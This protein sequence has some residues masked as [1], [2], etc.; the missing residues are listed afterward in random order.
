LNAAP[1][2]PK[3]ANPLEGLTEAQ[4]EAC[5]M[6]Y[7]EGK[8]LT[9]LRVIGDRLGIRRAAV[10]TRIKR[11]IAR[12]QANGYDVHHLYPRQGGGPTTVPPPVPAGVPPA[13]AG[14]NL[15]RP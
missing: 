2:Q 5:T 13:P 10:C 15:P 14:A 4:I 11:G 9:K 3:A 7:A 12:I 8:P 1:E 6:R